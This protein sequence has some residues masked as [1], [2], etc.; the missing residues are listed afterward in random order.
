MNKIP[1]ALF[2]A[3]IAGYASQA[4]SGQ[5]MAVVIKVFDGDTIL[6]RTIEGKRK[7]RILGIDTPEK[8]GPYTKEEPF[9]KEA[10]RRM[11]VLL[12]GR[13]V[14]LLYEG[15]RKRD[16]YGRDLATVILPDGRDPSETLITEGLAE[17]YR[18][19]TFIRKKRYLMLERQARKDCVGLW[20]LKSRQCGK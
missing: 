19:A 14:M 16:K 11:A 5:A 2:L 8:K 20:K 17:V 9:G 6:V 7:I 1:A 12:A 10:G 15:E 18:N 13:R 3:I 4:N